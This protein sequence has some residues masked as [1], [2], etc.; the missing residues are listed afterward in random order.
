MHRGLRAVSSFF[1]SRIVHRP[2]N[3]SAFLQIRA[4]GS[5]STPESGEKIRLAK[6]LA[7]IG[8]CSRKEAENLMRENRVA[9]DGKYFLLML[10]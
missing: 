3:F 8:Y 6:A 4:L 9:V 7:R 2:N 1:S 10:K 5:T